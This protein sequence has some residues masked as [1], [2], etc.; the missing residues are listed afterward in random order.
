MDPEKLFIGACRELERL[1]NGSF[2]ISAETCAEG[3]RRFVTLADSHAD[4]FRL[5]WYCKDECLALEW[6][7]DQERILLDVW[8][9]VALW[10]YPRSE[11]TS[12]LAAQILGELRKEWLVC[13]RGRDV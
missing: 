13:F 9:D 10:R 5:V 4:A 11:Q 1:A 12:E 3:S 8:D 2:A 6:A 7:A